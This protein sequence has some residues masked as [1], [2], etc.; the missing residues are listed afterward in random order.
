VRGL[1]PA[2][3]ELLDA[4]SWP[5]NVR[6]LRNAIERAMLLADHETLEPGDFTNLTRAVSPTQFKLPA[7]GVNLDDVERQLVVQALERAGNNQTRAGEL[8]GLN[9]DQVR[10]RMEKF[11][12]RHA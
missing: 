12:L 1:S 10:Y 7:E 8:L 9:R 6:E 11:G 5:G 2:A 4:Y 3:Q